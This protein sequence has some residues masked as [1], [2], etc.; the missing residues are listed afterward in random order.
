MAGR[1]RLRN[2]VDPM[3]APGMTTGYSSHAQPNAFEEP[4]FPQGFHGIVRA[5]G[6]KPA[7]GSDSRRDHPLIDPDERYQWQAKYTPNPAH[8]VSFSSFCKATPIFPDTRR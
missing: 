7:P 3:T 6:S 2:G 8:A 5:A 1:G 4:I